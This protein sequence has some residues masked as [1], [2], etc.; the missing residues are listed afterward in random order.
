MR[1]P[2]SGAP[3]TISSDR[4]ILDFFEEKAKEWDYVFTYEA[5]AVALKNEF[6]A[7]STKAVKAIMDHLEYRKSRRIIRP[8]LTPEHMSERLEWAEEW[9][10][11]NFFE[12]E[13]VVVHIDEK[14]FYAFQVS[15]KVCYL[16]PGVDPKPFYAL[17]KT[18]IPW[19]MF[20]G[21]VAAP[22][23]D[24]GFDG[25]IGLWHVGQE[26]IALKRSKF[27]E[28]GEVYWVNVNMDGDLFVDMVKTHLIPA[29]L[30]KCHWAKKV[31]I[32]LDSAG[33]HRINSSVVELN[34]VGAKCTPPIKFRTQ[35]CRSPDTNTLDLGTWKSMQSRVVEVKYDRN[36]SE[37]VNQRIINA[38]NDMWAAYPSQ[39]LADIFETL[40]AVLY[41]IKAAKG[42][43]SFKQ[44]RKLDN[45]DD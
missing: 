42:G 44:P 20:L 39:K 45:K 36:A 38:V 24:L 4:D 25:K 22:R 41:E 19:C 40:K 10:D 28:K 12:D 37:S 11:F 18:Q 32:Q 23:L 3:Q 7:G 29:V 17:S 26:K 15:G 33:G 6:H 9:A 16:P 13:T 8:F 35:A 1:K 2:G 14:C 27:R 43:N 34:E 31:I 21:A 30:E 5:M